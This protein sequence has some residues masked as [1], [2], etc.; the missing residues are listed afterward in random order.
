M[1]A[2][3]CRKLCKRPFLE[4]MELL[5]EAGPELII[6]REKDLG[7]E[8]LVALAKDC[9]AICSRHNV[10]FSINTDIQ[11]ARELRI[12]RIH[13]PMDVLREADIRGFRLVGASVHS[14]EEAREA[15]SLGVHYLI[16]GHVF[17]TACKL[18][19]PCGTRLLE[20]VCRAVDL[21][22]Y[23]IGGISPDNYDRVLEA[24]AAGAA[25]MSSVMEADDPA[26]IVDAL[27]PPVGAWGLLSRRR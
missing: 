17:P 10:P 20:D 22:V 19:E 3:T 7:H 8:E 12:P 24:G 15:S 14:V 21:P 26:E 5:A 27:R 16:L 9:S 23:G 4:Q 25:C 18:W 2:V 11:A 1:I 13:L 6:L